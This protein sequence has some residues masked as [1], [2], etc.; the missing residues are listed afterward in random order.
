MA[1]VSIVWSFSRSVRR[2]RARSWRAATDTCGV[3][4]SRQRV[5]ASREVIHS[6]TSDEVPSGRRH[7]NARVPFGRGWWPLQLSA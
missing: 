4:A 6:G 2:K 1:S 7:T 5:H 3:E